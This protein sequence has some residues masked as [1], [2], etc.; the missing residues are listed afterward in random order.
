MQLNLFTF[1][2]HCNDYRKTARFLEQ[3]TSANKDPNIFPQQM[4][5]IVYATCTVNIA[6]QFAVY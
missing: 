4:E 3:I 2:L 5:A 1:F 6:L